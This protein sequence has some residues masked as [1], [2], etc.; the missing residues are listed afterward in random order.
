ML[1]L[2]RWDEREAYE[3]IIMGALAIG[4][5][6]AILWFL[7][8][9]PV[10]N[11]KS[12][13]EV[14]SRKAL[15]DYD[16]VSQALPRLGSGGIK[17]SGAP[18]SRTVLIGAARTKNIRLTRVQPDGD[19]IN[20]WIDDVETAKLYGLIKALVTENGATL[21]RATITAGE[22]DLLSAQLTFQ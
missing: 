12:Q 3:K 10:L 13:A 5:A 9:S 19:N 22:N 6:F 4:L 15:R 7:A 11:A 14:Q 17:S 18:F 16:I 8:I 1:N 20:V 2:L 21:N